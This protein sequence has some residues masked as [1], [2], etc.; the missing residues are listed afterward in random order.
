MSLPDPLTQGAMASGREIWPLVPPR[1][2]CRV[3]PV[4]HRWTGASKISP[5]SIASRRLERVRGAAGR[6]PSGR[7]N[8]FS[9]ILIASYLPLNAAFL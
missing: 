7:K 8:L 2:I 9:G 6:R 1:L 3:C 4:S 5:C